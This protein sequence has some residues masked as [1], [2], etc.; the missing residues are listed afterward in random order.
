MALLADETM[1]EWRRRAA[2]GGRAASTMGTRLWEDQPV[3]N[4]LLDRFV[5][6]STPPERLEGAENIIIF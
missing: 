1:G 3:A 5:L 6:G 4:D 2:S